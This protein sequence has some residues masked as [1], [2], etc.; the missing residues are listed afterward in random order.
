MNQFTRGVARAM[1]GAFT[2]PGPVLEIG[3][4]Q[5]TGQE[6]LIDLRG[7]FPGREYIGVDFRPGPG[8]DCVASVEKLPQPDA[9]IGTVVAFS[10]FEH[11]ERFWAGFEEVY[12]VLRPDGVFLV[13]C[14]FYFHQHGFPSD[15]WRFT[16]QAFELLLAKYPARVIGWNGPSRRP[17]HVW[18]AA[19]REQ[20]RPTE[21][22]FIRFKSL[23]A[24]YGKEPLPIGRKLRYLLGRV[25]SGRRPFAPHLDRERW[26]VEV[27]RPAA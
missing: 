12:R 5:V 24:E 15:Y 19:F 14:P 3:S 6:N 23:L 10:A 9:S 22:Q 25:I 8:V 13:S 27:R 21:E 20:A 17:L 26:E 16:P 4:Y 1:A 7:L 2:L 11:V 18:A